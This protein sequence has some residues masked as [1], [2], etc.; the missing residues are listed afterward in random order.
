MKIICEYNKSLLYLKNEKFLSIINRTLKELLP[1]SFNSTPA[2]SIRK[3]NKMWVATSM[4]I[5]ALESFTDSLVVT[6]GDEKPIGLIGGKEV[7]ENIFKN[8]SSS[9]F[10]DTLVEQILEKN[11]V[12]LSDKTTLKELLDSWKETRRA[13]SIIPNNHG[14]YSAISAR[15]ILEIGINCT[16]DITISE[17]PKKEMVTFGQDNTIKEIMRLMLEKNLRK[18]LL[19]DSNYFISDRLL[20][21]SIAQ[22]FDFFRNVKFLERH[23]KDSFR[24]EEA[25]KISKDLNLT[26][27]SKIMY[28]MPHP[29][30]IYQDQVL[31]PW[32]ICLALESKR[33]EYIG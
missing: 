1:L 30:I 29:C 3:E 10:D 19:K 22:D 4:L 15:K 13:F 25:K 31:T 23:V 14:G 7:I 18:I 17:L 33:V 24:L 12:I 27:V 11:L 6:E 21:Q 5:H 2:V 28:A 32:D 8:P 26:E 20:I 9:F 16:T